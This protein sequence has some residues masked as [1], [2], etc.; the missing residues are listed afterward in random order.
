MLT[1][2]RVEMDWRNYLEMFKVSSELDKGLA[3]REIP[4]LTVLTYYILILHTAR[5]VPE[6]KMNTLGELVNCGKAKDAALA[7]PARPSLTYEQ[8][9]AQVDYTANRLNT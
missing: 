2:L 4:M 3:Q 7:A 6:N 8:L 1:A 9:R 5:F